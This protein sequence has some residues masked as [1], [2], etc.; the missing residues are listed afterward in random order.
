[1]DR[2]STTECIKVHVTCCCYEYGPRW[3][4]AMHFSRMLQHYSKRSTAHGKVTNLT[5]V[6]CQ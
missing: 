6:R 2:S 1:M 3:Q 4:G 5:F